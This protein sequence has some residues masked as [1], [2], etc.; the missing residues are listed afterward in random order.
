VL[1]ADGG[2]GAL[3]LPV[4][5]LGEPVLAD[6]LYTNS[7]LP[8]ACQGQPLIYFLNLIYLNLRIVMN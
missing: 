5:E 8:S 6:G 7:R 2:G 4:A 1:A 3:R